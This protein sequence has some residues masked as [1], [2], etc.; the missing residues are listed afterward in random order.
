[1]TLEEYI[2]NRIIELEERKA[3]LRNC[4]QLMEMELLKNW[5]DLGR[6]SGLYN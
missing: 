5:I 6:L 4:G 3:T 1:M 2:N